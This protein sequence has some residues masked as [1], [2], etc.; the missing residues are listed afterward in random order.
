MANPTSKVGVRTTKFDD[1][2][3]YRPLVATAQ[4]YYPGEMIGLNTAGYATKCDDAASLLFL[5]VNA[6]APAETI[7]SGASAGEYKLHDDRPADF[8]MYIASAAI[9]DIGKIVYAK[10]SNEVQFT[11]GTYGNVVGRV[12][13]Y[14]SS[15]EVI[16]SPTYP[17]CQYPVGTSRVMAA[18]GAQS[19]T[20]WDLNKT[21][22]LPNTAA[23]AL[24][25]PAV[26][27]TQ[28]GDWLEFVKTTAD[29][30]AVTLT[31]NAAETI[32]GANTLATIGAAYDTAK[33][34][35]TGAAWVVVYRDIA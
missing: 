26:A 27:V 13:D 12:K 29:A 7:E 16:I 24:T 10:Y 11:T 21:I 20:R 4:T 35:S 14:I 2:K 32:D 31:G 28:P 23:Y 3:R 9:T 33:I 1:S 34:V 22:F 5:G 25:L 19:L 17:L 8:S 6:Q 18:T 15:T 30:A